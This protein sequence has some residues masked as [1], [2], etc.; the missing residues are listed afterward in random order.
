MFKEKY[1]EWQVTEQ[2][3]ADQRR[4]IEI[5]KYIPD[6]IAKKIRVEV[7]E[8]LQIHDGNENLPGDEAAEDMDRGG[9]ADDEERGQN[10]VPSEN[11][12]A[13]EN[14]DAGTEERIQICYR[15]FETVYTEYSGMEMANR[16]FIQK[17]KTTWEFKRTVNILINIFCKEK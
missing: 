1:P 13:D 11:N 6:Q 7:R 16:P 2:R 15:R 14:S 12:S 3:I 9:K 17:Q 10:T 8:E 5:K 4:A